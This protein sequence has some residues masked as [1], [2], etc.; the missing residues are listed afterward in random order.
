MKHVVL[1]F[2]VRDC[3]S[4]LPGIFKNLDALRHTLQPEFN[5]TSIF[6]HD[7]CKDDSQNILCQYEQNNPD[8]VIV[9]GIENTST[10]RTVRIAKAR[11]TCLHHV[12]RLQNVRYHMMIDADDVCSAK[13]DTGLIKRCLLEREQGVDDWDCLSFNRLCYY[14]IWALLFDGFKHHCWGYRTNEENVQTIETMR[15]TIDQKLQSSPTDSIEVMSAFNGFA[16]YNTCRFHGFHYDGRGSHFANLFSDEDRRKVEHMMSNTF[17]VDVA[18]ILTDEVC[19]HLFY[20]VTAFR[21]GR[22]IKISKYVVCD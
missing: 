7:N 12:Y 6:V 15:M 19:E 14:D 16:I 22:K 8:R 11:N 9:E 5:M 4:Y 10:L 20:H 17:G 2:C 3:Q 13:W 18:C 1:C 21:K